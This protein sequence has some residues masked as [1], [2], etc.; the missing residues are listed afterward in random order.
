MVLTCLSCNTKIVSG[1]NFSRFVCPNCL[2]AEIIRCKSCKNSIVEY[3]C[4]KCGF[5][6]P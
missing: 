1:E 6:G 3:I 2:E 5:K 4:P